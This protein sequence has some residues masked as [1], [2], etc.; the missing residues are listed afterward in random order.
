MPYLHLR[1]PG[2]LP[3]RREYQTIREKYPTQAGIYWLKKS[4]SHKR[5]TYQ[6]PPVPIAAANGIET[7]ELITN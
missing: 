2:I 5:Q 6:E 3:L 4:D 7:A 1:T